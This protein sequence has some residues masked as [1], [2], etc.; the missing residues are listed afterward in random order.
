MHRY[1]IFHILALFLVLIILAGLLPQTTP[2]ER[3]AAASASP[4]LLSQSGGASLGVA[5]GSGFMYV[6][7]GPRLYIY[8]V[9]ILSNPVLLGISGLLPDVIQDVELVESTNRVYVTLGEGGLAVFST[10]NKT[11][12]EL[13]GTYDTPGFARGLFMNGNYAYVADGVNGLVVLNISTPTAIFQAAYYDTPGE[14]RMVAITGTNRTFVA[15]GTGGMLVF[16][17][18]PSAGEITPKASWLPPSGV[19]ESVVVGGETDTIVYLALGDAG[20]RSLKVSQNYVVFW[21][22]KDGFTV[23]NTPG[24]A[25]DLMMY[26]TY[27]YVADGVGG[28]RVINKDAT[29]LNELG[30]FDSA[31]IASGLDL[32]CSISGCYVFLADTSSVYVATALEV[33][34]P[35]GM[36]SRSSLA[37][38]T[39]LAVSGDT[40]YLAD[41]LQGLRIVNLSNPSQPTLTGTF[42]TPGVTYDVAVREATAYVADG[43]AGLQMIDITNPSL[44]VKSGEVNT[45]GDTVGVALADD[46]VYLADSDNGLVG[47]AFTETQVISGTF[48]TAGT[49]L[50]VAVAGGYAYVAD[51]LNGLVIVNRS[52]LEAMTLAGWVNT[53]GRASALALSGDLLYL[54]DGTSGLRIYHVGNPSL[55]LELGVYDTVGEAVDVA[56]T[57][58]M[59]Y[60]VEKDAGVHM[61]D[62]SDPV[63]PRRV[64]FYPTIG[65]ARG[66]AADTRYVLIGDEQG[67]L[68]VLSAPPSS[69]FL[70]LPLVMR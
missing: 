37:L 4:A 32:Y 53:P 27:L 58:S 55:P 31:G 28:L 68:L 10:V 54:A 48:N 7:M 21:E 36:A 1:R 45:P 39:R 30:D 33:T 5:Y 59:V 12:P 41:P 60:L 65:S 24:Y 9:S 11:T 35:T 16:E 50:D 52:P 43:L 17:V 25:Q 18:N 14:A 19:T 49:A 51:G 61:L 42:D 46:A 44:P 20:V 57:G 26:G 56:V 64:L 70:R 23:N 22:E 47:I 29:L 63:R 69:Y 67:G 8:N 3:A 38:P 62:V 34:H 6:G 66:V 15:D 40:A 13:L 2:A